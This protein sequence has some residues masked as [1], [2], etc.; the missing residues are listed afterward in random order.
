[1]AWDFQAE[2]QSQYGKSLKENWAR[3]K[4]KKHFRGE[5]GESPMGFSSIYSIKQPDDFYKGKNT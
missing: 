1:M 3:T 5:V 2:L 4:V